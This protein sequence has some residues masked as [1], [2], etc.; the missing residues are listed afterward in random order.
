MSTPNVN[1]SGGAETLDA[2]ILRVQAK[3]ADLNAYLRAAGARN[4]RLVNITI[5]AGSLAAAMTAGPA[6][7]GKPFAD[8]LTEVL[9]L[10]PASSPSWRLLCGV[11]FLCSLAATIATQLHTSHNYEEHITDAQKARAT[12]EVLA[13]G[14]MSGYLSQHEATR[15]Y[16]ECVEST[17][18]I[19]AAP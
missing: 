18:F 4:R 10:T 14:V 13:V 6:L 17:P 3:R 5:I 8:W 12:L 16:L 11:A 7:G 19:E 9:G 2:L 1:E 15:R